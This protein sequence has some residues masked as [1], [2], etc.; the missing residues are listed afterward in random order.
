MHYKFT[1]ISIT[2]EMCIYSC[3]LPNFKYSLN[4]PIKFS[5]ILLFGDAEDL[6]RKD[7]YFIYLCSRNT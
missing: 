3:D 4:F 6:R 1:Q 5:L 7:V 2:A